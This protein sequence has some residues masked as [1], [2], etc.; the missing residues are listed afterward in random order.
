MLASVG[1]AE[2]RSRLSPFRIQSRAAVFFM[3]P[4]FGTTPFMMT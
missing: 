4:W 3:M 1:S 2:R